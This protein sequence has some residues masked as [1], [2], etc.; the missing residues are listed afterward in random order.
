MK[1]LTTLIPAKDPRIWF[2]RITRKALLKTRLIRPKIELTD[3]LSKFPNTKITGCSLFL[4]PEVLREKGDSMEG[5]P[6]WTDNITMG[7]L[8]NIWANDARNLLVWATQNRLPG[9]FAATTNDGKTKWSWRRC[10]CGEV[11]TMDHR[12]ICKNSELRRFRAYPP[13]AYFFTEGGYFNS[14]KFHDETPGVVKWLENL[15]RIE[16][17]VA[18]DAATH[19]ME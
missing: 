6:E 16:H 1:M 2:I 18:T 17:D 5:L 7:G 13:F 12:M 10:T 8:W 3:E 4:N 11:F 14:A 19:L 9:E 15:E